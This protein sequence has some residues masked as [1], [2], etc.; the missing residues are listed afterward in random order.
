MI[1]TTL[2]VKLEGRPQTIPMVTAAFLGLF[3][4][5]GCNLIMTV[6][7]AQGSWWGS[8]DWCGA[9]ANIHKY[10][11]Y[12]II[13]CQVV[14]SLEVRNFP[15]LSPV[16]CPLSAPVPCPL[17]PLPCPSF[18]VPFLPPFLPILEMKKNYPYLFRLRT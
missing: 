17:S 1:T 13:Y 9:T 16:P 12:S 18:T 10:I 15:N 8:L 6:S 5:F 7:L 4:G 3:H 2:K 14:V 11:I